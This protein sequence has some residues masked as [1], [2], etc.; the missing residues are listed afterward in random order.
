MSDS[1]PQRTHPH[2]PPTS[3]ETAMTTTPQRIDEIRDRLDKARPGLGE[4][5][6]G[7]EIL[8]RRGNQK[9]LYTWTL[10]GTYADAVLLVNARN[11]LAW[12]LGEVERLSAERMQPE[13]PE[14]TGAEVRAAAEESTTDLGSIRDWYAGAV[15][16]YRCDTGMSRD[17]AEAAFDRWL[18][19]HLA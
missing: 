18:A 7:E 9:G 1:D 19:A 4:I 8:K 16:E 11:D 14:P 5:D 15:D 13:Q 17:E 6:G 12:L 3:Q 2:T 10:Y